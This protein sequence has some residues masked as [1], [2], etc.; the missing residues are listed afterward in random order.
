MPSR[1]IQHK[2]F[3]TFGII[4]S[5]LSVFFKRISRSYYG[6]EMENC[7]TDSC[8]FDFQDYFKVFERNVCCIKIHYTFLTSFMTGAL[9]KGNFCI[10][11]YFFDGV[12]CVC[13]WLKNFLLISCYCSNFCRESNRKNPSIFDPLKILIIF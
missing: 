9:H 1:K 8:F 7:Q 13:H 12:Y 2:I 3:H 5:Y 4:L 11:K 6:C 10:Q